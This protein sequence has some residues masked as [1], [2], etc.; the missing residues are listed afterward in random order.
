MFLKVC[1]LDEAGGYWIKVNKLFEYDSAFIEVSMPLLK[2]KIC[3]PSE[4]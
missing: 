1:C 3:I 4:F 2:L